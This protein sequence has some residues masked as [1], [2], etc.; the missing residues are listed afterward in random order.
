MEITT[1]PMSYI[2]RVILDGYFE[3]MFF[4]DRE[5]LESEGFGDLGFFDIL[6]SRIDETVATIRQLIAFGE[7]AAKS[8]E[9]DRQ[10]EIVVTSYIESEQFGHDIW[11]G[12]NWHGTGIWDNNVLPHEWRDAMDSEINNLKYIDFPG[13][14]YFPNPEV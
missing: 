1:E 4:T 12:R 11:L 14:Y 7:Q 5:E 6:P 10:E 8:M 13:H 3:A 9:L 2:E